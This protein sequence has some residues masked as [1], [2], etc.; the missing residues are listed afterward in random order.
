MET[1]KIILFDLPDDHDLVDHVDMEYYGMLDLVYFGALE[2]HV[3]GDQ[4][5]LMELLS[6]Y[7]EN[8]S[9]SDLVGHQV[10]E[11]VDLMSKKIQKVIWSLKDYADPIKQYGEFS[12]HR[13]VSITDVRVYLQTASFSVTLEIN[14]EPDF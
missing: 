1:T 9:D 10:E 2:A 5:L 3:T 12:R 13:E 8:I 4:T 11:R 6:N 14:D 7:E